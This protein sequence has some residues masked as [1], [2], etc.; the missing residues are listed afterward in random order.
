MSLELLH[1]Y[2]IDLHLTTYNR[3]YAHK[4]TSTY[5]FNGELTLHLHALSSGVVYFFNVNLLK[6]IF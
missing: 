2:I 3:Y 1:S 4:K 5:I 6:I